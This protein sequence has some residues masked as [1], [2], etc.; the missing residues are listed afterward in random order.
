MINIH[1]QAMENRF[2]LKP[3]VQY[4]IA[5]ESIPNNGVHS[6]R[7]QGELLAFFRHDTTQGNYSTQISVVS[8]ATERTIFILN[9]QWK[10]PFLC[11]RSIPPPWI[12]SPSQQV[13]DMAIS[14]NLLTFVTTENIL[15]YANLCTSTLTDKVAC[16]CF[17]DIVQEQYSIYKVQRVCLVNWQSFVCI[18]VQGKSMGLKVTI[19]FLI[20]ISAKSGPQVYHYR[21]KH[22]LDVACFS[23]SNM[24]SLISLDTF[25]LVL[26]YQD[27]LHQTQMVAIHLCIQ[28]I[29]QPPQIYSIKPHSKKYIP[30]LT[31][32]C[33]V[34]KKAVLTCECPTTLLD[35]LL[36]TLNN[37]ARLCSTPFLSLVASDA[38]NINSLSSRLNSPWSMPVALMQLILFLLLLPFL[39]LPKLVTQITITGNS[40]NLEWKKSKRFIKRTLKNGPFANYQQII[41]AGNK[42]YGIVQDNSHSIVLQ[43]FTPTPLSQSAYS[44]PDAF[45]I[46]SIF[47]YFFCLI[48]FTTSLLLIFTTVKSARVDLIVEF[49]ITDAA[50]VYFLA[51]CQD[52]VLGYSLLVYKWRQ[53]FRPSP[54]K[55]IPEFD[56]NYLQQ[57][58]YPKFPPLAV[59]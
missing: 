49:A 20:D 44:Q 28:N 48:T 22:N 23:S 58:S 1:G 33:L 24:L 25:L 13:C 59:V 2:L 26:H 3:S 52:L 12:R 15:I 17:S 34:D 5:S 46:L 14:S 53:Y 27:S 45:R 39:F 41:W 43:K 57:M 29:N 35:G 47:C 16:L 30:L 42:H 19:I 8:L 6:V 10:V 38:S 40:K 18:V 11:G 56:T 37:L 36:D 4:I 32:T 51:I 21:L 55:D 7:Y 50:A 9:Y 31:H 54:T